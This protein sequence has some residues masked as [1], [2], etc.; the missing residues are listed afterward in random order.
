MTKL[1]R[2]LCIELIVCAVRKRLYCTVQAVNF[3]SPRPPPSFIMKNENK[4]TVPRGWLICFVFF[5]NN[6]QILFY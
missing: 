1:M 6:L 4:E 2:H 3:H 5:P